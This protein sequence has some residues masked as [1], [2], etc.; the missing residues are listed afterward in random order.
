[1]YKEGWNRAEYW[2]TLDSHF[3]A[4][5]CSH[6][7]GQNIRIG[8]GSSDVPSNIAQLPAAGSSGGAFCIFQSLQLISLPEFSPLSCEPE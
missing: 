5:A 6:F 8:Q 3:G 1:L 2:Q 7:S 4:V